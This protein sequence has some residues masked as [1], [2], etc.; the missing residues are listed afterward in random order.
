MASTLFRLRCA[1][2]L[3]DPPRGAALSDA[4]LMIEADEKAESRYF[5]DDVRELLAAAL[6][7]RR[8]GC[9]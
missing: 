5:S 2:V 4:H 9:P 7:S 8:L 1:Q 6:R 3:V